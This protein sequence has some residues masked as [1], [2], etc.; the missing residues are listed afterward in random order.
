MGRRRKWLGA[1][2]ALAVAVMVPAVIDGPYML[3][4]LTLAVMYTALAL[5]FDIVAGHVGSISLAHPVFFGT[6]AYIAALLA[7][8]YNVPFWANMV[9]AMAFAL[10]LAALIAVP[11]FRLRDLSFAVA[12]LGL[13]L[14]AQIVALNWVQVT[15]GPRCIRAIPRPSLSL[16]GAGAVYLSSPTAYYYLFL[17]LAVIVGI[18]Y[19]L[20][21]SWRLGRTLTAIRNDEVL[22]ASV[23]IDVTR[24]KR[25]AFLS[26]AGLAGA[27]GS[28]W[29]QYV[30]V[31]CPDNLGIAITN[32]L[33][34]IIFVGGAAHLGGVV[35]GAVLLTVIPEALRIAPS[36]RL[37]LYGVVLLVTMIA[38]PDGLAQAFRSVARRV[39][40]R[41]PTSAGIGPTTGSEEAVEH[42][43]IE[44]QRTDEAVP[45]HR[46]GR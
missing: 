31:V 3:H 37:I 43:R 14:T 1:G 15:N 41:D 16:G 22:A 7:K 18:V 10:V 29:A 33:L 6:G 21:T 23:G 5:G 30:T 26:G 17:A 44:D 32:N 40:G 27:T 12:T 42:E 20:V 24:Y 25:L 19:V 38:M 9:T 45:R 28:L 34:I 46:R 2:L 36:V 11:G 39:K 13:A 8:T 4:V 35:A